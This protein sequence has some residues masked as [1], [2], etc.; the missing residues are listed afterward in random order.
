MREMTFNIPE[1]KADWA[2]FSKKVRTEMEW[3]MGAFFKRV[4]DTA[5]PGTVCAFVNV[6][7]GARAMEEFKNEFTQVHHSVYKVGK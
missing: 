4:L 2:T 7:T 3:R 6:D 1:N 5:K